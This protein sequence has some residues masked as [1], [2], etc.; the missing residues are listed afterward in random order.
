MVSES[1]T[2]GVRISFSVRRDRE[3]DFETELTGGVEGGMEAVAMLVFLVNCGDGRDVEGS[4]NEICDQ[5]HR[6]ILGDRVHL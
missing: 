2:E 1:G 3:T 4:F 6:K 5:A